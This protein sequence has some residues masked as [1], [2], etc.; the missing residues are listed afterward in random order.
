MP[1]IIII[2]LSIEIALAVFLVL[3]PVQR[4]MHAYWHRY[5]LRK[6]QEEEE[7]ERAERQR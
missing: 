2:L 4:A 6:E 3:P 1:L 7:R 5:F